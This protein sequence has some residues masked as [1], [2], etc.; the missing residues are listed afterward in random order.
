MI[1]DVSFA[2]DIHPKDKKTVGIRLA[3][4]AL[5]K[6][7]KT[8]KGEINGPLFKTISFKKA[9]AHITFNNSEGLYMKGKNS[10]FEI[11]GADNIFYQAEIKIKKNKI[12]I[13]SKEVKKPTQVRYAWKNTAQSNIFNNSNLPA[14]TFTT[15]N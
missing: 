7:Y 13:C 11:A 1:D 3:N 4:N 12:T 6:H 9:K 10:L 5:F 8:Y 2:N 14:S 15:K